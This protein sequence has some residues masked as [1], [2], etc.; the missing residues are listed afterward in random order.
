MKRTL[1]WC[2]GVVA[3]CL[4]AVALAIVAALLAR[5]AW[6]AYAAAV[7]TK[8]YSLPMLLVRLVVGGLCTAGGACVATRIVRDA[9]MAGWWIGGLFLALALPNHL[10]R[11]WADYPVWYHVVFLTYLVPVAGI[12]GQAAFEGASAGRRTRGV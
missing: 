10:L 12:A 1:R 3:G 8:A 7:P 6:P 4:T 5:T 11:V 9:R 2:A